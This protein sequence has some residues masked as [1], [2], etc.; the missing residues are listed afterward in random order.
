MDGIDEAGFAAEF[1]SKC[2]LECRTVDVG[3]EDFTLSLC[4]RISRALEEPPTDPVF[5]SVWKHYAVASADG[6][7]VVLTGQGN[8]ER[9]AGYRHEEPLS[10][11]AWKERNPRKI[12]LQ[13]RRRFVN[14]AITCFRDGQSRTHDFWAGPDLLDYFRSELDVAHVE[15]FVAADP[16]EPTAGTAT[17][18]A[19][20]TALPRH[21]DQEDRLGMAH[22]V[23]SRVP[24]LSNELLDLAL[25]VQ[26]REPSCDTRDKAPFRRTVEHWL[27]PSTAWRPKRSYRAPLTFLLREATSYLADTWSTLRESSFMGSVI[28]PALTDAD[29]FSIFEQSPALALRVAALARFTEV[30]KAW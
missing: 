6:S 27:G 21:L 17:R 16:N 19:M 24:L 29:A 5:Y 26:A 20:A 23:E 1:A 10:Y 15:K 3:P 30:W 8:D 18:F 11:A 7:R 13:F 28:N 14:H 2:G 22:G 25:A 12:A 9:W 4:D